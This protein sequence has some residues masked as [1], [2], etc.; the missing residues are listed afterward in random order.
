MLLT[1]D[2]GN[3]RTKWAV[4]HAQGERSEQ[5]VCRN[6]E[7]LFADFSPASLGYERIVISNVAGEQHAALLTDKLSPYNLPIHWVKAS[8]RACHVNNHYSKPESL[9]SDRWAALI[10]AWH[11]K[12]KSCIVVTAG[13]AVT[14]DALNSVGN[15]HAQHGEFIGGLILPGLNLMQQ[16]L[17]LAAAQLPKIDA[18]LN[19]ATQTPKEIF[20]KNTADAIYTGALNAIIGAIKQMATALKQFNHQVPFIVVSGG[21]AQVLKDN[22]SDEVT[23]QVLFVDNLVLLG[24]YLIDTQLPA[25]HDAQ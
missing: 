1:I 21:N 25:K 24:L 9:G 16:M 2:A 19:L 15:N 17:G 8:A 14:I 7:L 13:T 23:N 12:H 5:F 22:L 6:N 11:M 4:F 20:A 18:Q 10:A 3:T